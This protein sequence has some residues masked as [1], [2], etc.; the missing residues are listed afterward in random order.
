MQQARYIE[1]PEMFIRNT[2]DLCFIGQDIIGMQPG[3][4]WLFTRYGRPPTQFAGNLGQFTDP[5]ILK[6]RDGGR[7]WGEPTAMGLPWTIDGFMS[8]GGTSVLRLR[9]GKLIFI[10]HRN[11]TKYRARG[12]HGLPAISESTDDGRTWSP[13]RLLTDEPEDIQYLMNQRLIQLADGRL[14]LPICARD[15]RIP[16]EQFG[17][18]S[19]PTLAFCYL[20]DDDGLTWRRSHGKVRQMT[21][22]GVQEPVAGEY[23]PGRLVLLY[24]SGLGCHQA[25]FSDDGGETWS[26]PEDT[27]LTAA[28]SPLTMTK[29]ADGSLILVYNHATPLFKES[30]YPRNPLV[31]ATS[32][33]GRTWSEP[34]MIDDQPG[35]QLIYPS[36]TPTGKGLLIAYC[37]HYDAG[38]GG[39]SF[40]SD[41]WKTGG[42]KRTILDCPGMNSR[43]RKS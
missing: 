1:T 19:H 3:E 17:E 6:S 16:I 20:S 39:F 41:A 34:V 40:P 7:S 15:P 9:S 31:Y 13:A 35:R 36:I 11:G 14:V 23:A 38:D 12:S 33:D 2:A 24:R 30:Y 42:G 25:S 28:C 4:L 18:G 29:L 43:A 21:E 5:V 27:P 22:R 26:E 37:V 8:D 32:R 10:S